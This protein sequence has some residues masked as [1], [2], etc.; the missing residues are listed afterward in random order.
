MKTK[1]AWSHENE[2]KISRPDTAKHKRSPARLFPNQ[3]RIATPHF[4]SPLDINYVTGLENYHGI[5]G[6]PLPQSL[7]TP[8]PRAVIVPLED[9]EEEEEGGGGGDGD[10]A[11][12]DVARPS[13]VLL[14]LVHRV[15]SRR[16]F[17]G[18]MASSL[19]K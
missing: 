17:T 19:S 15:W 2:N 14:L 5:R 9:E 6:S 10:E 18:E 8:P 7:S 4:S 13:Q 12:P 16:R 11:G 3:P 1:K